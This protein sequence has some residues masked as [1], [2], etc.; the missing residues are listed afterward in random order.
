MAG[1]TLE[2]YFVSL[3][4]KGQN[5]VLSNID[6]VRKKAKDLSKFKPSVDFNKII[7]FGKPKFG[8]GGVFGNNIIPTQQQP[9][10]SPEQKKENKKFTD[11]VNK[12]ARG[13]KDFAVGVA[14]FDPVGVI[15]QAVTSA[16][17]GLSAV[18]AAIPAVGAYLKS[19]PTGMAEITKAV[20]GM[21]AGAVEIGK[22][23]AASYYGLAQRN[24]MT[25]YYGG[26]K[27]EI[28]QSNL[29]NV[30]YSGLI[31]EISSSYGILQKPMQGILN[32]LIKTK[33]TEMLGRVAAGDWAS[34]GTDKGWMLQQ[35]SN[36]TAGLP[37]SIKQAI[38]KSLLKGNKDMIM[39]KGSEKGVQEINA[40]FVNQSEK[41]TAAL[42]NA[43]AKNFDSL[44]KLSEKF[45]DIEISMVKSGASFAVEVDKAAAAIKKLPEIINSIN[46]K[47]ESAPGWMKN[48][49]GLG[50]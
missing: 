3:G 11:G 22:Q 1:K 29:S 12:F 14:H 37:P 10:P 34:T 45:N 33:N 23:S 15:Q 49:M 2:E 35:I 18:A 40:K 32:E 6:K 9:Q 5:V 46:S 28:G 48:L 13:T 43:T 8:G 20:V 21:A 24:V 50:K 19:L 30:Q 7:N 47:M 39:E 36:Q 26:N 42:Y 25:E 16:G 31:R 17:E 27:K 38:Q 4:V 44:Y 41:Q